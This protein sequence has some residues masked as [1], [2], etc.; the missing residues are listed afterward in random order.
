MRS[1]TSLPPYKSSLFQIF[2][3]DK[4]SVEVR[5]GF[6]VECPSACAISTPMKYY[7]VQVETGNEHK[8]VRIAS[9]RVSEDIR[10]VVWPRR[11]LNIR[12]GG[13]TREELAA[14]FPGYVFIETEELSAQDYWA[15]RRVPGFFRFLKSNHNVQPLTEQD[16]RLL[17]HFLSFGEVVDKSKV[18]FGE[19]QRIEVLEGPLKGLEGRIVKVDKRKGRAKVKLDMYD[20]SFLVDFGFESMQRLPG[21]NADAQKA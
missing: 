5:A 20:E 3:D 16:Q 13:R 6:I 1:L 12:R 7:V 4:A 8:F 17:V 10:R 14:I 11:R 19:N 18:V 2:G 9:Q 15:I 21:Q